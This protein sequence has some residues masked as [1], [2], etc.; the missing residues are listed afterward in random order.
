MEVEELLIQDSVAGASIETKIQKTFRHFVDLFYEVFYLLYKDYNST[1]RFDRT[2]KKVYIHCFFMILYLLQLLSLTFPC[3][4][5]KDHQKY[6][7][8]FSLTAICRID[9]LFVILGIGLVFYAV[10][11]FIVLVPALSIA[12][13]YY[14]LL[15]GKRVKEAN[16]RYTLV[17]PLKLTNEHLYI[18]LFSIFAVVFEV[19]VFNK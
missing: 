14:E 3:I 6:D 1:D 10:A 15:T 8:F 18:S 2:S 16:Y 19:S 12:I 17:W 4:Q 9:Y 13:M 7:W 11:L 5:I